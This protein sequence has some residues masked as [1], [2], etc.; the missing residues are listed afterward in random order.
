MTSD[1]DNTETSDTGTEPSTD[2]STVERDRQVSIEC[3]AC[4]RTVPYS[5]TGR[6]PRY[7]SSTCRK[8]AW[9]LREAA[10]R[11]GETPPMPTVV[12]EVVARETVRTVRVAG[13]AP[14]NVMHWARHI[15][16][17]TQQLEDPDTLLG[18]HALVWQL[19]PLRHS[20]AAALAAVDRV[21]AEL[22]PPQSAP[23]ASGFPVAWG[24]PSSITP[25]AAPVPVA[26]TPVPRVGLSRQQRRAL[27]REQRKNPR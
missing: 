10:R 2:F 5:G 16:A 7:C 18:T 8:Q 27:E 6:R 21:Q 15:R 24:N 25:P 17:L 22:R 19:A 4:G 3:G 23:N 12:R 13:R 1:N 9:A 11:A 14:T 20:L 26:E